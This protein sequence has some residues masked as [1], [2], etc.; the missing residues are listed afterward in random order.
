MFG[1]GVAID[2]THG[3]IVVSAP[4]ADLTGKYKETPFS[5]PSEEYT[6]IQFPITSQYMKLFFDYPTVSPLRSGENAIMTL[7]ANASNNLPSADSRLIEQAGAV[8][9]FTRTAAQVTGDVV[10]VSS[11]WST[12]EQF[13]M[14]PPDS[15]ARD[16]FGSSIALSQTYLFAGSPGHD[17]FGVN[18]GAV[19]AYRSSAFGVSFAYVSV[20]EEM[21]QESMQR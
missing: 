18:Q 14:Q 5:Y 11:Y 17:R 15:F 19:Y 4:G 12:C 13:K 16:E 10:Q 21:V 1:H 7:A 8:Y 20:T 2:D 3:I 6:L 9:V